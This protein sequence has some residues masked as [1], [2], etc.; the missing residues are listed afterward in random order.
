[1]ATYQSDDLITLSA[2]HW[3]LKIQNWL[4]DWHREVSFWMSVMMTV[5]SALQRFCWSDRK[6]VPETLIPQLY[7]T[8]DAHFD[9]SSKLALKNR[10]GTH[11]GLLI[12]DRLFKSNLTFW[13]VCAFG[14]QTDEWCVYNRL[15]KAIFFKFYEQPIYL[16]AE[17]IETCKL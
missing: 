13:V 6:I 15:F 17:I 4:G 3:N 2:T 11:H 5:K 8:S 7:V 14:R 12:T 9:F 1:L 16:F 10:L